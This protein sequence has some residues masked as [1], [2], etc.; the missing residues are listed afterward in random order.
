MEFFGALNRAES[1]YSRLVV[2]K[3]HR[4]ANTLAD[5]NP[6]RP[7]TDQL[8]AGGL[9]L[10]TGTE[11]VKHFVRHFIRHLEGIL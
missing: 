6:A 10:I 4:N 8:D 9:L 1:A 7:A 2:E 5:G 3:R 11:P